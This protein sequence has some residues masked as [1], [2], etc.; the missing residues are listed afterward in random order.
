MKLVLASSSKYRH[1]LLSR[2]NIPFEAQS[3]AIN[4]DDFKKFKLTPPALAQFLAF[5]KAESLVAPQT[6]IIGSDQLGHLEGEF[7]E[8]PHTAEN[9]FKQLRFMSGKTIELITA[10]CLI[11]EK[12]KIEFTDTT[13]LTL[14]PLSDEQIKRYIEADQPLDCAGSFKIEK[15]GIA[16]FSKIECQDFTAI[17]GLPLLWLSQQLR[18]LGFT[19]P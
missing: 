4:E 3:P 18:K 11:N 9:A 10:V 5:K 16:L 17:Q 13:R 19:T 15:L 6:W 14:H 1:E 12:E 7:L 8:K 2:L